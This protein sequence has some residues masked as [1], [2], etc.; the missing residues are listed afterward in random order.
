M[1]ERAFWV[2][3]C[4]AVLVVLTAGVIELGRVRLELRGLRLSVLGTAEGIGRALADLR[5][6]LAAL[7]AQ[8]AALQRAISGDSAP[9]ALGVGHESGPVGPEPAA[10]MSPAEAAS[11]G[12]VLK[13]HLEEPSRTIARAPVSEPTE[14]SPAPV[15][16]LG[17]LVRSADGD[18][19][20]DQEEEGDETTLW[21]R[22]AVSPGNERRTTSANGART[23]A[24]KGI[25]P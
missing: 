19:E 4:V 17:A 21:D 22:T 11:A 9:A 7:S 2:V 25:A 1:H 16:Y 24:A 20:Q 10:A 8:V 14:L 5:D 18:L 23:D 12:S 3:A 6:G 15:G 13:L